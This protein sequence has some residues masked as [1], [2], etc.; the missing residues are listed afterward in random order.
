[1]GTHDLGNNIRLLRLA[2]G[3]TQEE[4]GAA[5]GVE[6][7]TISHYEHGKREPG[8]DILKQIADHYMVSAGMLL[9][10]EI[11]EIGEHAQ[12]I[13]LWCRHI[14]EIFPIVCSDKAKADPHFFT[15]YSAHR[16]LWDRIKEIGADNLGKIDGLAFEEDLDICFSE[17]GEAAESEESMCEIAANSIAIL[18]A[19]LFLVKA[20]DGVLKTRS[21][22]D[23]EIKEFFDDPD[24][25]F[26]KVL[27][28][29]MIFLTG[30]DMREFESESLILLKKSEQ[31]Y[32]VAD[33]YLALRYICA[34]EDNDLPIATNVAISTIM[35]RTLSIV[36]NRFATAY[37]SL[38]Q[39]FLK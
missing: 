3:E 28:E 7:N 12:N 37:L 4:L 23:P 27:N 10:A 32:E 34:S 6:K 8:K 29:A 39:F 18:Y 31:W 22:T 11:P 14:D 9:T 38:I 25:G 19:I 2:Y 16:R 35:M 1:M 15:A 17:Y 36:E 13:N 33:Y 26:R 30:P 21:M 5:I 24:S 20:L